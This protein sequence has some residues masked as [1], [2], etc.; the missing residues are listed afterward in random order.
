MSALPEVESGGSWRGTHRALSAVDL[1]FREIAHGSP[2]LLDRKHFELLDRTNELLG[3]TLQS[4]PTFLD[5]GKLAELQRAA[6][7]VNRLLRTVP[8]RVFRQDWARLAAFYG[9]DPR[10]AEVLFLPPTGVETLMSR[11]DFIATAGG[12]KCIEINVAANL[13]G[14]ETTIIAGLQLATPPVARFLDSEG[15]EAAFTDTM[16]E[17]FQHVVADLR[18]KGIVRGGGFTIAFVVEPERILQA[19]HSLDFLNRE[20][21]R[22]LEGMD[23]DLE[24][25]V[26]LCTYQELTVSGG[27]ALLG[28]RRIA[29]VV[30]QLVLPAAPPR[31]YLLFRS[32][33]I[34]LYNTPVGPLLTDKRTLAL[35]SQ[36]AGSGAYSTAERALIEAWVPWTRLAAP[37]PVEYQGETHQLTA[38]LT[39]RPERFVLKEAASFGGKNVVLGRSV[40][41]EQWRAAVVEAL[42]GGPWIVQEALESLPYL[43]QSGAYGCSVHDVIWGLFVFGDRYGGTW[44]RMQPKSLGGPVSSGLSATEGIALE[45]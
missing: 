29:A 11:G 45:V 2:E 30:E 1:R 23:L 3:C 40:P 19:G 17:M 6:L 26:V 20:L 36:H 37:G 22:A 31:I 5:A 8:E 38:L 34:G 10:A 28:D 16:V 25:R 9:L 24:G 13:G 15:I 18:G 41:R 39:A 32:G 33:R 7:E 43:Y 21:R 12:F 44:L 27:N 4:W 42:A 14:A 35:L